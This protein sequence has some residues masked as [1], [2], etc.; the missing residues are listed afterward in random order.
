M[1][2]C[3]AVLLSGGRRAP[4]HPTGLFYEPT[5]L[6]YVRPDM[7]VSREES[8]AYL[9]QDEIA[10]KIPCELRSPPIYLLPL[11]LRRE[12]LGDL[13]QRPFK[14]L[15]GTRRSQFEQLDKPALRVSYDLQENGKPDLDDVLARL[16]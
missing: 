14:K 15:P 16:L 6:V 7:E 11:E 3:G 2:A 4:G 13:N 12:L 5:V 1:R 8:F 10:A 9:E